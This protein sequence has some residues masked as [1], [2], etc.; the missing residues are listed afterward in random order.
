MQTCAII[1][2]AGKGLRAGG[3]LP[4]QWQMLGEMTVAARTLNAFR[5]HPEI[6][7]I[8]L[9][10]APQDMALAPGYDGHPDVQV[11][12]G[13]QDRRGSVRNGLEALAKRAPERVLIHDVARPLVSA[14]LISK[15]I[16]ALKSNAGAAPAL[17][18]TDALWRGQDSRVAASVSRDNLYRAQTPQGFDYARILAAHRTHSGPASDDVEI[19]VAAGIDVAI[20]TGEERN[21]KLTL[22]AD[23]ERAENILRG[24]MDIRVGNGFDVHRFS[25]GDQV[26]LCGLAVPHHQALLGHSDAD[27]AMHAVTDAIYGALAAGDIGRHF[28]PTDPQWK[29]A[30]SD[31]FLT[32]A[33][34]LA[35]QQGYR[36]GNV[37][38]TIICELPKIAPHADA[39]AARLAELVGL[40]SDRVSVKATTS[41][42]LGFTGRGEGI[43]AQATATLIR[44]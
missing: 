37:D 27:V 11:V 42:K 5:S 43:A 21:L 18:V 32:H 14:A 25:D 4:K 36:I 23:F 29:G 3:D 2:A 26:I 1:V 6:G 38:L 22:A 31:T 24:D 16:A 40:D 28:P 33:R 13:D 44:E 10:L 8:I 35:A 41:E 12:T 19:A 34:N 17:T 9:V 39:M 7:Q 20:V 15:I 30:A